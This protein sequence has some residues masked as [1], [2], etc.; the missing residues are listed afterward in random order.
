MIKTE[1]Q[2]TMPEKAIIILNRQRI[3]VSPEE[4]TAILNFMYLLAD[5]YL[6][7]DNEV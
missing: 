3:T 2:R 7:R 5:I 4:A 6:D 1:T